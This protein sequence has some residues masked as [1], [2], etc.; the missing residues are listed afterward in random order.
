[1]AQTY[2]EWRGARLPTEAEWKE[3]PEGQVTLPIRGGIILIVILPTT[4][5]A[6]E[7]QAAQK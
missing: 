3:L 5:I 4:E 2:C 6:L 1:M 7:I